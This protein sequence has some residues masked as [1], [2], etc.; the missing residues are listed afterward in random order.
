MSSITEK[1]QMKGAFREY[2]CHDLR[3]SVYGV[4]AS[5]KDPDQ[6][7]IYSQISNFTILHY[8]LQYSII[9]LADSEGPDECVDVQADLGL[10]YWHMSKDTFSHGTAHL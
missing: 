9:Q 8:V 1:L 2:L 10:C 6:P 3:K 7:V 5:C 4:I